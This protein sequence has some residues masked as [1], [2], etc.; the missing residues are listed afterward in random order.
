VS[1][2]ARLRKLRKALGEKLKIVRAQA[3]ISARKLRHL[4]GI[5]ERVLMAAEAGQRDLTLT[6]L[7]AIGEVFGKDVVIDFVSTEARGF[8]RSRGADA[9]SQSAFDDL[10]LILAANLL[11]ARL[12]TGLN[13]EEIGARAGVS[14]NYVSRIERRSLNV[15]LDTVSRLGRALG[16]PP[17]QLLKSRG[18]ETARKE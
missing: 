4:S 10:R 14:K 6:E 2:A 17:E 3:N 16:M 13:Y 15:T 9:P 1:A 5:P 18:T 8:P 12:R 7:A 11:E